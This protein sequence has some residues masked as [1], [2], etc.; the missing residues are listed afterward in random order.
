MG[1]SPDLQVV[2]EPGTLARL[3]SSQLPVRVEDLADDGLLAT[4]PDLL[5]RDW[6][7][8]TTSNEQD[9]AIQDRAST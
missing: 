1:Q 6:C 3:L 4:P 9:P 2:D 7:Q 5:V 8:Q